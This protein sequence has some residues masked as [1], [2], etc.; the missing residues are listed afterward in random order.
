MSS[1]AEPPR[2]RPCDAWEVR[3]TMSARTH[4][5]LVGT[6][7]GRPGASR[8]PA[9][10]PLGRQTGRRPSSSRSNA[11][12]EPRRAAHEAGTASTTA[13]ANVC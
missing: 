2:E 11:P 1:V 10:L 5:R 3:L 8:H 4:T 9:A 6:E 7:A 12:S 13:V